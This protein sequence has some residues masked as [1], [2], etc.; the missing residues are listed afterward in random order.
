MRKL[1]QMRRLRHYMYLWV[2]R[3]SANCQMLNPTHQSEREVPR[4][5]NWGKPVG[6]GDHE[7]LGVDS[8]GKYN[9]ISPAYTRPPD[10]LRVGPSLWIWDLSDCGKFVEVNWETGKQCHVIL[11]VRGYSLQ[12]FWRRYGNRHLDLSTIFLKGL[13]WTHWWRRPTSDLYIMHSNLK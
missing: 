2:W 1:V 7:V 5:K 10:G 11:F 3:F 12:Q 4:T 8:F 13:F 9:I 6:N